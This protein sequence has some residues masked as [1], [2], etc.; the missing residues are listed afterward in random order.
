M[1]HRLAQLANVSLSGAAN[2]GVNA[3][4]SNNAAPVSF[5]DLDQVSSYAADAVEDMSKS[6]VIGGMPDGK[7][8]PDSQATRAQAATV[9]FRLL[10]QAQ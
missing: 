9:I 10:G 2:A 3:N 8:A 4:T 1:L 6:G 7:F 5:S